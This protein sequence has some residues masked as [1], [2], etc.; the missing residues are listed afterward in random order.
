MTQ[1][2]V[3]PT[4]RFGNRTVGEGNPTLIIAEIGINH[5]GSAEVC[6]QM[7]EAAARSGANSVKLQTSNPKENY[8]PDTESYRVYAASQLTPGETAKMFELARSL[9]VEPFTTTGGTTLDWVE[10]MEPAA[11]KVS[12]GL[13][14]HIPLIK[15]FAALG[16]PLLMSTG[17]SHLEEI[18]EAVE[19]ARAAGAK[20][21]A[22]LQCTSLY[23]APPQSLNLS[24][25][26]WLSE[27]FECPA[28]FSDHSAGITAAALSVAAGAC[29]IEK[30]FTFDR[31][32]EGFD[33]RVSLEP[34]EFASMVRGIRET[35][36]MMG[37][38]TKEFVGAQAKMAAKM[39]RYVVARR[40]I[41]AGQTLREEDL[42]V[43]RVGEGRSGLHPRHY[44]ELVGVTA[45]QCVG[46][47]DPIP[48]EFLMSSERGKQ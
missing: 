33:H 27:T 35:E 12:S 6:A 25:I 45:P 9:G 18:R 20:D 4:I 13:M 19:A 40:P 26:G 5:E 1:Q 46:V 17:I 34:N 48:N 8:A 43:G 36:E 16:R 31:G 22:L 10:A 41:E 32:R 21:I 44:E 28:G 29:V 38:E 30:H 14:A 3:K 47:F 11:Y 2:M 15:R 23:P 7:I 39:R 37:S 24:A 42:G